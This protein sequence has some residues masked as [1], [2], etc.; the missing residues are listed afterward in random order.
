M[1]VASVGPDEYYDHAMSSQALFN[2]GTRKMLMKTGVLPKDLRSDLIPPIPSGMLG[3]PLPKP[4]TTYFAIGAPIDLAEY[5]GQTLST[6]KLTA[7]RRQFAKA[8]E[9][10]FRVC[11]S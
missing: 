7:L 9:K 2:S 3:G 8:I 10:R 6:Q 11:C 5:H 4:K 1:P